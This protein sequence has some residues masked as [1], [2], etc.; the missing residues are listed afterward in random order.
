MAFKS[1]CVLWLACAASAQV[2][3]SQYDNARTGAILTEK[4]L[5]PS[6]VNPRQF[7]KIFSFAVDG[8]VYAQPL[9]VPQVP[10]PGKG[11]H[12]LIFIATEHNSVYAFDAAGQP[13]A[14]LWRVN[15]PK[16]VPA[17]DLGCGFIAPQVGITP[18]PVIDLPTGTLYVLSRTT[19]GRY[20]QKLHALAIT[21][22]AEKFG[23]PVEIQAPGFDGLR[24]LP[25]AALLLVN[26]SVVLTWG[27]SC[28]R[29]PY[30]GWVMAYDAR[31]LQRKAVFNTS[32]AAGES[33]IWQSDMGP[34]ADE[35]GNIYVATGNGAFTAARGGRDYGDSLLKLDGGLKVLDYFTP[36]DERSL[37][38]QDHDLGSGGPIVLPKQPG[39]H[40]HLALIAGKDGTLYAVDRDHMGGFQAEDDSHAVQRIRLRGGLYAAPAY[41]N[42]HVYL[43]ARGDYLTDFPLARGLLGKPAKVGAQRFRDSGA[44]PVISSNGSHDG[45]LWLIDTK[46]W[47]GA[48]R[49]A[50]LHAYDAAD[51]ERELYSS[52]TNSARDRA[53][54]TL[55]FTV[56][57]VAGG[58]VYVEAKR[59][60]DVYGLLPSQ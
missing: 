37:N 13:S 7:G 1:S 48:D 46:A 43:S 30:H 2:L 23:G 11:T 53:G 36:S 59:E 40:P 52:E 10:V 6:N 49:P 9:F 22:G 58:R 32:P 5:T 54:N 34:A 60:V 20:V 17:G 4:I 55:R 18:T 14:P 38:S 29:G 3:T 12:D 27:S 21:T 41:W 8:D 45:I 44:T 35:D 57:T 15:F 19:E 31:T 50:V 28:D 26:G 24:E 47:N 33:G 56:P 25:R 51:V 39:A 16:P 42:G